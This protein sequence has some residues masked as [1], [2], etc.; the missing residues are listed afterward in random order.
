VPAVREPVEAV[1]DAGAPTPTPT[2]PAD[3]IVDLTM[4]GWCDVKVGGKDLGQANPKLRFRLAPGTHTIHCA[5]ADQGLRWSRTVTLAP[6]QKQDVRGAI[7]P[8][9][10]MS[11]SLAGGDSIRINRKQVV[12]NGDSAELRFGHFLVEVL[13]GGVPV[14]SRYVDLAGRAC[15]LRDRPRV[16][17][18]RSR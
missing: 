7:V 14:A 15:T 4:D 12:K 13:R 3:A 1:P 17:C 5:R 8:R 16:E 10:V 6:G 11:V 18:V 9:V 2:P